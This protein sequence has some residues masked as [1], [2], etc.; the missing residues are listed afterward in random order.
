[1]STWNGERD[2]FAFFLALVVMI[3]LMVSAVTCSTPTAM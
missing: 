3:A 2:S 1:M